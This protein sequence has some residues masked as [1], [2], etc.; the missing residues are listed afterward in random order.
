MLAALNVIVIFVT[1]LG[2]A[3]GLAD[4]VFSERRQMKAV[5]CQIHSKL[6]KLYTVGNERQ[7]KE[8]VS[9]PIMNILLV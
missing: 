7:L 3:S 2:S 5:L 1:V 4:R 9:L 6:A 8:N